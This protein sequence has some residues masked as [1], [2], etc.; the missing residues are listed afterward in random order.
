MSGATRPA[1]LSALSVGDGEDPLS[2]G[3]GMERKRRVH[4]GSTLEAQSRG[5]AWA[6]AWS[7]L[8]AALPTPAWVVQLGS[9][10]RCTGRGVHAS[11]SISGGWTGRFAGQAFVCMFR[12]ICPPL[13]SDAAGQDGSARALG[14]LSQGMPSTVFSGAGNQFGTLRL[15]WNQLTA[16]VRSPPRAR[17]L[18]FASPLSA[19]LPGLPGPV[20]GASQDLVAPPSHFALGATPRR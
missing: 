19:G 12:G 10:C 9:Q 7:G 13:P 8:S 1:S 14:R 2:A 6:W 3:N 15:C 18:V 20:V 4:I 5:R 17:A 11:I 16:S